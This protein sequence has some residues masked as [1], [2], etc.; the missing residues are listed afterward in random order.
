VTPAATAVSAAL[1]PKGEGWVLITAVVLVIVLIALL[2]MMLRR[3]LLR[4]MEHRATDTTDSWT[5]AGRRFRVPPEE[6]DRPEPPA[7]GDSP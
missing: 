7:D 1:T 3:W 6:G 4:P 2:L 5:E